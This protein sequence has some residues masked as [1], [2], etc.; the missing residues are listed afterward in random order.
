MP[1]RY[2]WV[3]DVNAHEHIVAE[4]GLIL[5]K[6]NEGV[7]ANVVDVRVYCGNRSERR[8]ERT[9]RLF[10]VTQNLKVR[11]G[12]KELECN[13]VS[14]GLLQRAGYYFGNYND[15]RTVMYWRNNMN[16]QAFRAKK[17]GDNWVIATYG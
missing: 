11:H 4:G 12:V 5:L 8:S 14:V 16:N 1:Y 10:P 15:D 2:P 6:L 3:L 17:D 13:I 9:L 7:Y